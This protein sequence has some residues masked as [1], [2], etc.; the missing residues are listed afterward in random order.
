M[1]PCFEWTVVDGHRLRLRRSERPG[2]LRLVLTNA[3]PQTIRCWDRQWDALAAQYDLLAVD[4]PGFGI[5]SG[6]RDVMRP[7][8][9]ADVLAAL[10]ARESGP[11]PVLVAPDV[12]V[13]IALALA[14]RHPGTVAALVLFDGPSD[15]P[16]EVSWEGRLLYES[17]VARA[18]ASFLGV[19]FTLETIRRGYRHNRP[20]RDAV[21]EY[22][23]AMA[24]PKRF[25]LTL[26]FLESYAAELPAIAAGLATT[27]APA[28][29]A[30][31]RHDPFLAP[32]NG[33]RLAAALPRATWHPFE[34]ASHYSHEDAGDE[35]LQTLARWLRTAGLD[36]RATDRARTG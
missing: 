21:A 22:V 16:P 24:R 23:R 25:R 18:V 27:T 3:W 5:S 35:F 33:E 28:L 17:A 14:Q 15:Y 29:V 34:S 10:L 11:A 4:L 7:S 8:A 1:S 32:G 20:S 26:A 2:A 6:T 13:P 30:W 9:Q 31:G 12:G 36:D 19:P